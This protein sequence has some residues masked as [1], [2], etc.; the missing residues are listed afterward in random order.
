M[1]PPLDPAKA[2]VVRKIPQPGVGFWSGALDPAAKR[3]YAG[4]TDSHIHLY[5]LPAVQPSKLALLK[6]HRSYVTALVHV[7][8]TRTL[9]SGSFAREVLWWLPA[10]S[11]EPVRRLLTDSRVNRL[12]VSADG[13][14]VAAALDDGARIWHARSG[15]LLAVLKGG[16]PPTTRIGRR[17]ALYTV[18][19][20]A[21]GKRA[22]TGDR[23]G[24]IC[25]WETA[26]GKLL[27]KASAS[28][29]YSQAFYRDKQ[30]SEYEWGGV[31]ALAFS[32][33]GTLLAAGGMGPADQNSAGID[34]PMRL[35]TFDAATGKGRAG[36]MS[37]PKGMLTSRA[38]S[39]AGHWLTYGG[40][41]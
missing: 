14:L 31:K 20:S 13:K 26:S 33:D 37:A 1:T 36:V 9:I 6:G 41:R 8:G 19:L 21:D 23:A 39:P 40:G 15:D 17:N 27:H 35:E 28:A 4:G 2:H 29:F 32:P 5:D 3:L 16:H 10:E 25:L 34:G 38:A 7:P 12:A 30:N 22:A 11:D 24:T 18:A